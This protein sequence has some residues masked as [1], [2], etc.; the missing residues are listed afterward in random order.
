MGI[1]APEDSFEC[2]RKLLHRKRRNEDTLFA[3]Q[4]PEGNK[5]MLEHHVCHRLFGS[6]GRGSTFHS[7]PVT[8]L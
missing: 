6:Q 7:F 2:F 1:P 8:F 4:I 3:H 5:W